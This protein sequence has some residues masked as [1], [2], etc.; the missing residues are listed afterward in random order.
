MRLTG[1]PNGRKGYVVALAAGRRHCAFGGLKELAVL[2]DWTSTFSW[3]LPDQPRF[4][5]RIIVNDPGVRIGL[6]SRSK[7]AQLFWKCRTTSR[8]QRRPRWGN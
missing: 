7:F 5:A 4:I 3:T 6:Y 2:P 1:G 8:S